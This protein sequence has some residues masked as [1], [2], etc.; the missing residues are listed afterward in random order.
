MPRVKACPAGGGMV[1]SMYQRGE[2]AISVRTARQS[3]AEEL[4]FTA[5]VICRS[6]TKAF[7]TVPRE[8]FVGPGPWRIKSP[9]RIED[10][11]TTADANPRHVYHDV[12]IALDET[13]GINNG[14]PSLW[15][16]LYDELNMRTGMHVVHV[17]AGAGYYTAIL[18][19]IV[20]PSGRV[21]AI[22]VIPSSQVERATILL[23]GRR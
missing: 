5:N 14:Q 23:P 1:V 19:E 4:R 22:E 11:W 17:G 12:L 8:H 16:K 21:I 7:A 20:G 18:A 3:Y 6:V 13:R 9:M 10:Y 15:A 2:M